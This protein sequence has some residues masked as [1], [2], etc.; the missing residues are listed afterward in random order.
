MERFNYMHIEFMHFYGEKYL[1]KFIGLDPKN[2]IMIENFNYSS[3][4]P[5]INELNEQTLKTLQEL[6]EKFTLHLEEELKK[7]D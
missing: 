3:P 2:N 4:N 7:E 1:R 5:K 6:K